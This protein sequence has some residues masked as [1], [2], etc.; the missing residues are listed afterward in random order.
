MVPSMARLMEGTNYSQ[1]YRNFEIAAGVKNGHSR[2]ASFNDG[3]FYKFLECTSLPHWPW[4]QTQ[5]FGTAA[6]TEI[7][8]VIGYGASADQRLRP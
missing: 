1:F 5:T 2:G 3:D 4:F 7:I 8:A 6:W